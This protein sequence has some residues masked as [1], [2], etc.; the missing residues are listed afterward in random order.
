MNSSPT[1]TQL[2]FH[3]YFRG[4]ETVGDDKAKASGKRKYRNKDGAESDSE[5][6]SIGDLGFSD[7]ED[8]LVGIEEA[9]GS[10]GEASEDEDPLED[11]I[12]AAMRKSM[13]KAKGGHGD[14][15]DDDVEDGDEDDDVAEF[16]YSDSDEDGQAVVEAR[17]EDEDEDDGDEPFRSAFPDEDDFSD[18]EDGGFIEDEDD[19]IGSDEDMPMFDDLAGEDS[20]QD[21]EES[22]ARASKRSKK[23]ERKNKKRKLKH[24]PM[25]ATAEDYAHLLG[26]SDDEDI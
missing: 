1:V 16:H 11:E 22:A 19:L 13:P 9:M 7:R 10:D 2:F 18:D 12:W 8:D 24:M 14:D 21:E 6:E 3:K 5:E 4:K 26:N 25:F 20:D 23:D 15:E 17:D